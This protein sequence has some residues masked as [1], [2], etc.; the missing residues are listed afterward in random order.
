[1]NLRHHGPVLIPL[2]FRDEIEG[3]S[4][5][6]LMDLVWAFALDRADGGPTDKVMEVVREE[7]KIVTRARRLMLAKLPLPVLA[8]RAAILRGEKI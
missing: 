8:M 6:A 3:F 1:M 7:A 2:E 4:K 5:A